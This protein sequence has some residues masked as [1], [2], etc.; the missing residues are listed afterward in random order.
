[1]LAISLTH[2]EYWR[3]EIIIFLQGNHPSNDEVYVKGMQAR[4]RPYIIIEEELF[5]EGVCSPLLK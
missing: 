3:I 1:V 2:N 5:K 4:T